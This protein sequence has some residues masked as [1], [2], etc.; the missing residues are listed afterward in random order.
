MNIEKTLE[1]TYH[2]IKQNLKDDID[3]SISYKVGD[4]IQK[5]FFIFDKNGFFEL[6]YIFLHDIVKLDSL[7]V[8]DM[9]DALN[10]S[11]INDN[12]NPS[13][14]ESIIHSLI[15]KTYVICVKSIFYSENFLKIELKNNIFF[16]SK[17]FFEQAG[18][19][20]F[21]KFDSIVIKDSCTLYFKEDLLDFCITQS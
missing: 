6:E 3:I 4:E 13:P 9:Q 1:L 21:D 10:M 20:D 14:L 2:N 15:D 18:K 12:Q 11:R 19:I 7:S 16:D 17:Y 5:R 8:K